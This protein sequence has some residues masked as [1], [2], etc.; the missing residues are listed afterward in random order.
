MRTSAV[1][2]PILAALL[3]GAFGVVLADSPPDVSPDSASAIRYRSVAAALED[4]RSK[5]GVEVSDQG[6]WT[7]VS[8]RSNSTLW[9]FAPPGNA[10]YPAVVK[11]TAVTSNLA[12]TQWA[13]ALADD[14]T[15]TAALL[16]RLLHHAHIV[17]ISGE[18][19]RLKDRR[20]AGGLKVT[21]RD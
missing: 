13:T 12:F 5:P 11:R 18:S 7:I 2:I 1:V 17:Q 15:L 4:L 3:I 14:A 10:A 6:G 19:Y 9:S 16:D 20:K 21:Q 8:D